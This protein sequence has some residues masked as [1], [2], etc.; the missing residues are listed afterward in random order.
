[1][2]LHPHIVRKALVVVQKAEPMVP[3]AFAQARWP[4]TWAQAGPR[5]RAALIGC[6]GRYLRALLRAGLVETV[7]QTRIGDVKLP[8]GCAVTLSGLDLLR[9]I[10]PNGTLFPV[11]K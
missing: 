3:R 8:V 7:Y 11:E 2:N 4:A 1:M 9:L 10:G 5:G 6:A